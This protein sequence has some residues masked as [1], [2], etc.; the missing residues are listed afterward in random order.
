MSKLEALMDLVQE[1]ASEYGEDM[2]YRTQYAETSAAR[3]AVQD[4]L[5]SVLDELDAA[6]KQADEYKWMYEG[7]CK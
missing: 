4:A 2:R 1:Y 3:I 6:K 5:K 7:L